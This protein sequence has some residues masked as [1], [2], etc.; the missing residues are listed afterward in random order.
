MFGI[1]TEEDF[2]KFHAENLEK[3][4]RI[5]KTYAGQGGMAGF[6]ARRQAKRTLKKDVNEKANLFGLHYDL[7]GLFMSAHSTKFPG[8]QVQKPA[9][10]SKIRGI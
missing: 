6:W 8:T 1:N 7:D 10:S 5:N 4:K 9:N 3:I 2:Q